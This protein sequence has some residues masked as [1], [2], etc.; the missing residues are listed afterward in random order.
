M[1]YFG[2]I[3]HILLNLSKFEKHIFKIMENY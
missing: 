3:C 1:D 2:C